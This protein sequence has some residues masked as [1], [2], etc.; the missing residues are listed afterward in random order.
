MK[1]GCFS[2]NGEEYI[3]N[4]GLAMG[5]PLSPV[6]A[7]LFMEMLEASHFLQIIGKN[8]IWLR[9]VDDVLAIVPKE[10]DLDEKL[11]RLNDVST[12]QHQIHH[13]N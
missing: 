12:S 9:Y 8:S 1:F 6:A 13:R 4:S 10:T 7:C 2:Y 5:S 11:E 3:Q